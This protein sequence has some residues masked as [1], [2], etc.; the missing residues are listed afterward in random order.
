MID[1]KGKT[2]LV[3]GAASGIGRATAETLAEAGAHVV[4]ADLDETRLAEMVKAVEAAGG[5]A[6]GVAMDVTSWDAVTA[7]AAE[8][9]GRHGRMD[10]LVNVAGW[11]RIEPFMQN[12]EAF[13]EKIVS[14][15]YLGQVRVAK[16]F[17]PPMIEAQQGMIV[18]VSSDAGRVGSMGETV[19]AGAKGGVIAF[20]KSLAREM[21]RHGICVNCVCPGPT[22]TPLFAA[23]P[24]RMREAL[25]RVIPFRRLGTP[26]DLANAILFFASPRASYVTG[27]VLSVS[28]GL[29]MSG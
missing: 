21:A 22:D 1:L 5:S 27:Q 11:D 9:N 10:I 15:N 13:I 14:L 26:Q 18:N 19:Y 17:L 7:V 24:D 2:A 25:L 20:T 28:G 4:G 23:Q 8:V 3:T 29:T 12:D 16:A 6:E